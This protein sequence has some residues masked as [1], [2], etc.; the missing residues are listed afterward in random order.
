MAS[1]RAWCCSVAI[2]W[3]LEG[4]T[5]VLVVSN[6]VVGMRSASKLDGVGVVESNL[7][8]VLER[9]AKN[10]IRASALE[11]PCGIVQ[12]LFTV[13]A[14]RTKLTNHRVPMVRAG[15]CFSLFSNSTMVGAGLY[16]SWI[17]RIA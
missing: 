7:G 12:G 2:G 3:F 6:G 1:G 14:G 8:R 4:E 15:D 11:R 9:A 17:R 13:N 5:W 10:P 16:V